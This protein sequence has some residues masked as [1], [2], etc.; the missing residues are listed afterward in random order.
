MKP[1]DH[2]LSP[3]FGFAALIEINA[4]RRLAIIGGTRARI[5]G[6]SWPSLTTRL[7]SRPPAPRLRLFRMPLF[8]YRCPKTGYR[9]QGFVAEDTS[10]DQHVYEPVTCPV[11][12]QIH[13]VNPHTGV[14]LGE[15]VK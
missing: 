13:H 15:K 12:N 7:R 4:E 11:C 2:T 1:F 10:E 3:G 14:V 9:V 8:I 5:G 6:R